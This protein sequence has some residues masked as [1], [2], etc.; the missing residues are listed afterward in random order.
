MHFRKELIQLCSEVEQLMVPY[1]LCSDTDDRFIAIKKEILGTLRI[2]YGENS[3]EFKVVKLTSLPVTVV[4]V[5]KH[6]VGR[7]DENSR[8]SVIVNL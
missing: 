7:T 2:L 4:K 6:I 3:R 1:F 5:L 8:N